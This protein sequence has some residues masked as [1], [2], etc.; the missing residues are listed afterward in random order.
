MN[1]TA[2]PAGGA[3][4]N[5]LALVL[6]ALLTADVCVHES[7][8]VLLTWDHNAGGTTQV[9]VPMCGQLPD[10]T[11]PALMPALKAIGDLRND[12]APTP[13]GATRH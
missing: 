6:W 3:E 13:H 7:D 9:R 11:S 4:N 2:T 10:F 8:H 1:M 12:M 5:P